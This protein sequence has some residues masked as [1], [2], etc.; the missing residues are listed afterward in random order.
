[1]SDLDATRAALQLELDAASALLHNA[2]AQM[3]DP[4]S[5]LLRARLNSGQPRIY[6]AVVLTAGFTDPV[7]CVE[8]LARVPLAAALE[9]LA[10]ALDAHREL[11]RTRA[12]ATVRGAEIAPPDRI[13]VGSAI[14]TGDYC[15][16][17]AAQLAA[18]TETP[19]VVAVFAQTLQEISEGQLRHLFGADPQPFDETRAL[20]AS[21]AR[22]ALEL[23][24]L[25]ASAKRAAIATMS[26]LVFAE[27]L[28]AAWPA[29][30]ADGL[31]QSL[32]TGQRL[33][34][35]AFAEWLAAHHAGSLPNLVP[36]R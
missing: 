31:S 9:M 5:G 13:F 18:R 7:N 21:G 33:R 14:L 2:G 26:K 30:A 27:P 20:V 28:R 32:T 10:I 6:A 8:P 36:A 24:T 12:V 4:L 22:A 1:M 15:F 29:V 3:G 11:L 35:Q 19:R 25:T 23:T 16:S 34:W 17:R